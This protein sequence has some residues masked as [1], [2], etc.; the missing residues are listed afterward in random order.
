M[1]SGMLVR[2]FSK[3]KRFVFFPREFCVTEQY[4]QDEMIQRFLLREFNKKL[5]CEIVTVN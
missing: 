1:L 2:M 4:I 3:Q 5:L